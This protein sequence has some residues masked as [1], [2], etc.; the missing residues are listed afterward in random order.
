[1]LT[2]V[3]WTFEDRGTNCSWPRT[4]CSPLKILFNPAKAGSAGK[5]PPEPYIGST[6]TAAR[7]LASAAIVAAAPA[8]SL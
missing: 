3:R 7:S 6:M 5:Q 2:S 1:M 8:A 4:S